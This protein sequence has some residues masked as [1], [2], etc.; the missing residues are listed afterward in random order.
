MFIDILF[1]LKN[2]LNKSEL[3][4]INNTSKLIRNKLKLKYYDPYRL[5][6]SVINKCTLCNNNCENVKEICIS[7]SN[8]NGWITCNNCIHDCNYSFYKY[9]LCNK[10][11][12]NTLLIIY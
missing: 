2:F 6:F 5:T 3:Y 7:L 8:L 4:T 12:H 10:I 9:L 11:I 1:Y